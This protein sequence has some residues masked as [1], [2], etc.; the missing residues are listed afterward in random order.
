[1]YKLG[2]LPAWL[3]VLYSFLFV[4]LS[5]AEETDCSEKAVRTVRDAFNH[6]YSQKKY[7]KGF[8]I[9]DD[10]FD[11][12]GREFYG[13]GE[14][15]GS[16]PD[17]RRWILSD[18]LL[19]MYRTE[20]YQACE[21]LGLS[22][23]A[24][25]V[26]NMSEGLRRAVSHNTELCQKGRAIGYTSASDLPICPLPGYEEFKALPKAWSESRTYEG[27]QMRKLDCFRY[28]PGSE[29]ETAEAEWLIDGYSHYPRLEV[30]YKSHNKESDIGKV[31]KVHSL[32]WRNED[33]DPIVDCGYGDILLSDETLGKIMF[34][35]YGRYCHG[36]TAF[37]WLRKTGQ[38]S[39]PFAVDELSRESVAVK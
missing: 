32:F 37:W 9:L 39:F 31:H 12:C 5:W 14:V 21:S 28:V 15:D 35:G 26:L 20:Q 3:F 13:Y 19:A 29:N 27:Y 24:W 17:E 33:G 18:Y 23:D 22:L 16:T 4:N 30:V 6:L 8:Q 25:P 2:S 36:G 1:M 7:D 10:M 11:S 34:V 38:I